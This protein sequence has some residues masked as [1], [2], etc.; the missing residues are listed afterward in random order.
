M[1]SRDPTQSPCTYDKVLQLTDQ[2]KSS[3][4]QRH[5]GGTWGGGIAFVQKGKVVSPAAAAALDASIKKKPTHHVP[6]A[7]DDK[8]KI[9]ANSLGKKNCFNC[10]SDDHWGLNCPNLTAAQHEELAGMVHISIGN[11]EFKV[12]CKR[13]WV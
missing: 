10:G 3:Y 6:G 1:P 12:L 11:K 13:G 4:Q 8:G 7:K 2:Y 9:L 5:T